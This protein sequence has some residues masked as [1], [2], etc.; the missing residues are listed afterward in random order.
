MYKI[1]N[2]NNYKN[3]YIVG[4]IHGHYTLLKKHLKK[5]GFDKK[6]N[7]LVCTSDLVDRGKENEECLNL[8]SKKWFASVISNH[9]NNVCR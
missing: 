1:I 6:H 2:C 9:E 7:L 8:L 3:V 5:I 4:D